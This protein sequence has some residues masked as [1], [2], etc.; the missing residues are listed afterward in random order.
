MQIKHFLLECPL[1][2]TLYVAILH[3]IYNYIY[4]Y[5]YVYYVY[6]IDLYDIQ[7]YIWPVGGTVDLNLP[8][9]EFVKSSRDKQNY[10]EETN[11][12]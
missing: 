3:I 1:H 4:I 2:G 12:L 10:A 7:Q 6:K 5:L 9:A 8:A 11:V